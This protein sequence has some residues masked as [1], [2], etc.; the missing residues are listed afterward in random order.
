M[1][2]IY[3]KT[4]TASIIYITVFVLLLALLLWLGYKGFVANRPPPTDTTGADVLGEINNTSGIIE[5]IEGNTIT[6]NAIDVARVSSETNTSETQNL[7]MRAV[8]VTV[9][10]D[11]KIERN[12]EASPDMTPDQVF[13]GETT[14]TPIPLEELKTGDEITVV[15]DGDIRNQSSI[16]AVSITLFESDKSL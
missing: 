4:S 11:T 8:E 3:L 16:R 15:S 1:R 2:K 12:N 7:P 14:S 9:D 6:L 13:G 5:K 10:S